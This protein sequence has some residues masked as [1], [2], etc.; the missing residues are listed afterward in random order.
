MP[1]QRSQPCSGNGC[2]RHR[3]HRPN[4]PY[5]PRI[6]SQSRTLLNQQFRRSPKATDRI[7]EDGYQVRGD[8]GFWISLTTRLTLMDFGLIPL[9][10]Y[11]HKPLPPYLTLLPLN[12]K[13]IPYGFCFFCYGNCHEFKLD[14]P[15]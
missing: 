12:E 11:T 6:G 2:T 9:H 1:K 15:R 13:I 8:F 7:K 10:P 14:Y 3:L 4:R 5:C